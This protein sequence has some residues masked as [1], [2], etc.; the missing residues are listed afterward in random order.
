MTRNA[1]F[2][3]VLGS[4]SRYILSGL[5]LVS[6]WGAGA[7]T[8][9][10]LILLR[11]GMPRIVSPSMV[12]VPFSKLLMALTQLSLVLYTKLPS[13]QLV[14]AFCCSLGMFGLWPVLGSYLKHNGSTH[15][16]GRDLQQK[17]W[18][19]HCLQ[20]DSKYLALW[21]G[22][23]LSPCWSWSY[24]SSPDVIGILCISMGQPASLAIR[25]SADTTW[26]NKNFIETLNL[27]STF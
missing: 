10:T 18:E 5:S 17:P 4:P 2:W 12:R 16:A 15:N 13:I 19:A 21:N 1:G 22:M 7:L 24:I 14:M 3:F 27:F 8:R 6:R 20:I 9:G 11:G 26:N 23:N 25:I